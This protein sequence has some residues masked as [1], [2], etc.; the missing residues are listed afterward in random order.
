MRVGEKWVLYVFCVVG[1][2]GKL[3]MYVEGI[4]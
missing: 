3:I 2:D 1:N 4:L